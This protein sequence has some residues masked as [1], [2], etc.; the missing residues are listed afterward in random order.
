MYYLLSVPESC[1]VNR[2]ELP[3]RSAVLNYFA[4]GVVSDSN[5]LLLKGTHPI[6]KVSPEEKEVFTVS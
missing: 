5:D 2:S 1:F 4:D 6:P 3:R